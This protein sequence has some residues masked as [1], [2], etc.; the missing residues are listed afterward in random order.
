MTAPC[1]KSKKKV[2]AHFSLYRHNVY[3]LTQVMLWLK[4]LLQLNSCHIFCLPRICSWVKLEIIFYNK[5][6]MGGFKKLL[7]SPFPSPPLPSSLISSPP[8]SF[9]FGVEHFELYVMKFCP[10]FWL[11]LRN[12]DWFLLCVT[13]SLQLGIGEFQMFSFYHLNLEVWTSTLNKF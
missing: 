7:S 4:I 9:S 3:V 1:V 13:L 10:F 6:E 2:P 11:R 12:F 5:V 8:L